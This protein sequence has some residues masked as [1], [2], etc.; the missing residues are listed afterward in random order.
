MYRENWILADCL[1]SP[2]PLWW[3][4]RSVP[5]KVT[6]HLRFFGR[7]PVFVSK[8]FP[9]SKKWMCLERFA[10]LANLHL[11]ALGLR[12]EC[13]AAAAGFSSFQ[14]ETMRRGSDSKRALLL[15]FYGLF[16]ILPGR[17]EVV[18]QRR[19]NFQVMKQK[20]RCIY[21]KFVCGA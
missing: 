17:S 12:L 21:F 11:W 8:S 9:R 5:E 18:M 3:H 4:A 14:F 19:N 10:L 6:M 20:F 16:N 7:G 15:L 13:P 2:L 1:R